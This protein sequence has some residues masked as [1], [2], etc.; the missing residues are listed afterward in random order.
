MA[1]ITVYSKCPNDVEMSIYKTETSK[2]EGLKVAN[3]IK[4]AKVVISGVN[5]CLRKQGKAMH[6]Q[7]ELAKT[8]VEADLWDKIMA[9]RWNADILLISKQIFTA[10][11]DIEA[12]NIVKDSPRGISDLKTKAEADFEKLNKKTKIA[13]I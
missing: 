11:N 4:L 12:Y 5:S 8:E 13:L 10:K 9:E 7:S 6:M 1:K 3:S 2:V